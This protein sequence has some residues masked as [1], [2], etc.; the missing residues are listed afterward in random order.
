MLSWL[1]EQEIAYEP[2]PGSDEM[3]QVTSQEIAQYLGIP[4]GDSAALE[5]LYTMLHTD[6]W[7]LAG[8]SKSQP[9]GWF[10]RLSSDIWRFRNVQSVEDCI[11]ARAAWLAEGQPTMAADDD[12]DQ[13]AYYHVQLSTNGQP[14]KQY[15]R[16]D[17]TAATLE[18]HVLAPYR[19]GRAILASGVIVRAEDIGQI[20]IV[21]TD[22]PRDRIPQRSRSLIGTVMEVA[23][24][25]WGS[26]ARYG[27]DV[28]DGF[29]TE[30]PGLQST[31]ADDRPAIS[32]PAAGS[33][34]Y[35]NQQVI[36]AIR[37]KVGSATFDVTKLL[38]L[39]SEL[40]D[41]YAS[42]NTYA[43]HA[44]LRA[45]L[46]H[47]PPILGCTD[48]VA[49]ANNFTWSRTDKRYIKRL[50]DFRNQADD[51]LHRQISPRPDVLEFD[52]MPTSVHV[53][54]LLQECA[55]KL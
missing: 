45:V 52:D 36:N 9:N 51:A 44:L 37:A 8:S 15:A 35:V 41:N 54:R 46:D 1:A 34:P 19:E 48:F 18:S 43:S 28:T 33:Q 42:K 38:G 55:D 5:R 26:V 20:W 29:V 30:P 7:G 47:V 39:I 53:D 31:Q 10:V 14:A 21:Q 27:S 2:P 23:G 13:A 32:L 4:G 11:A 12:A 25:A 40:N 17:L 6:H 3:P 50:A 24:G 22:R 16:Y 49:V